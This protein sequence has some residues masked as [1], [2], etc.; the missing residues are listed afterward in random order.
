MSLQ[1]DSKLDVNALIHAAYAA[2]NRR[3]I[4]GVLALM[5]ESVNWPRASEEGRA[6]GKEEIRAYWTRQ[7]KE[8]DPHVEPM[9]ITGGE[10]GRIHVRVHQ[11]VKTLGGDLLFDGD[12]WHIYTIV[13]GRID[14]MDI[15][16]SPP[17]DSLRRAKGHAL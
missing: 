3:D 14:R 13:N 10:D 8:F 5:T 1:Q 2:F 17:I 9:E 16:D 11:I 12:V 15:Q 4:D 7:W 6:I